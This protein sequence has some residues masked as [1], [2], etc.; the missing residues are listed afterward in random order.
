MAYLHANVHDPLEG[1]NCQAGQ[2]GGSCWKDVLEE[3]SRD[4]T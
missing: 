2:S 4:W 1:K 3:V